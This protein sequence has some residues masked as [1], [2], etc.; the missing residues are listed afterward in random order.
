M[1]KKFTLPEYGMKL[2]SANMLIKQMVLY[3]YSKGARL[4]FLQRVWRQVK[5]FR[6]FPLTVD[7]RENFAA[8]G[9]IPGGYFKREGKFSD[10]EV[11]RSS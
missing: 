8:A 10:K 11:C 9:K 7:Y 2:R 5:S 4:F 3:G 1:E 6:V